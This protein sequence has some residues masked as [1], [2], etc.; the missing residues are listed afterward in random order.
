MLILNVVVC[1]WVCDLL[2]FIYLFFFFLLKKSEC[3]KFAFN[4][5]CSWCF[6]FQSHVAACH[7][8]T[9][10]NWS[11]AS[12]SW[13]LNLRYAFCSS[14]CCLT[15][16][17]DV[18]PRLLW[19]CLVFAVVVYISWHNLLRPLLVSVLK[20]FRISRIYWL[21]KIV[22][23]FFFFLVFHYFFWLFGQNSRVFP[24]WL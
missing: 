14:Y 24:I 22:S 20:I 13:Q 17:F 6:F 11:C 4:L 15:H 8:L 7:I 18:L 19:F 21:I 5:C 23:I 16:I 12:L 10:L 1:V 3:T 2:L 9:D